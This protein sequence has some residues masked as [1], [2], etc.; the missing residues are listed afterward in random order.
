MDIYNTLIFLSIVFGFLIFVKIC[1]KLL[2]VIF[3]GIDSVFA[4][5]FNK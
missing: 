3:A 1:Y 4:R 2:S 5:L